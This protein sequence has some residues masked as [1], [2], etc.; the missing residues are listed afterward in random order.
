MKGC[1][2]GERPLLVCVL[3]FTLLCGCQNRQLY[4]DSRI[5]MGTFIE[6]SSPDRQAPSIAFTEIKRIERLLSIYKPDSEISSLNK[7]GELK[8]SPETFYII[9]KAKDFWEAS[10]SAFDI[11][12]GPLADLWGFTEKKYNLPKK[13]EIEKA[14][15]YVGTE[16]IIFN[17]NDNVIK[18]K[19][20]GTKI[21][22]GA[23]AKGYAVDCA[24]KKLKEKGI[25]NCLINAGGDIYCLGDKFGKPWSVAIKNPRGKGIIEFLKLKNKAVATSGDYEQYFMQDNKRYSH[26][27]NPKTGYPADSGVVSVT[28]IAPDCLTADALATSIFVLGKTKGEELAKKFKGVEVKIIEEKDVSHNK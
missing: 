5:M 2:F 6:I 26:I 24:I 8:A 17:E 28:V 25:K 20:L 27:F 14:L 15:E 19:T 7:F 18:F 16:K 4:K 11:T 21:G 1:P 9:K 13:E 10:D 23:I 22:L 3:S 12:V